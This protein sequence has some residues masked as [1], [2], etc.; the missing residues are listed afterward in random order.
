MTPTRVASL[1][2]LAGWAGIIFAIICVIAALNTT[3]A[4]FA[5]G[6][7]AGISGVMFFGFAAVINLL[8][9]IRTE[10]RRRLPDLERQRQLALANEDPDKD[11]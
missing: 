10:L 4:A 9:D 2:G 5:V 1:L 8:M 7:A 3:P 6:I 11:N